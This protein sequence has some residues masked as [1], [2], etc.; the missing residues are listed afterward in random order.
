LEG[1]S[2]LG[3]WRQFKAAARFKPQEY[4]GISKTG[5]ERPT[6]KFIRLRADGAKRL[7]GD[8]F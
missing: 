7:F 3:F 8:V 2:K 6:Q 4:D 1:I 5:I